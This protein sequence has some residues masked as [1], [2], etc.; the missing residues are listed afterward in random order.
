MLVLNMNKSMFGEK[1]N[2][3]PINWKTEAQHIAL[4]VG[5]LPIARYWLY[6]FFALEKP[7]LLFRVLF[8]VGEPLA[9]VNIIK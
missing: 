7:G 6:I 3:L 8:R 4:L 2:Y 9:L 1:L 5:G